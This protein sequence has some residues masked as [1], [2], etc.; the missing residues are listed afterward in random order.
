MRAR[1]VRPWIG[2]CIDNPWTLGHR[3]S[4]I[5]R[6]AG[7]HLS[8]LARYYPV[9]TVTGPRQSGKTTLCRA[10]FPKLPYVSLEP[11]DLRESADAEPRAFLA[12]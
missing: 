6:D 8:T 9:V 7:V 5:P 3:N 10:T 1:R 4:V 2:N 11:L 12:Q